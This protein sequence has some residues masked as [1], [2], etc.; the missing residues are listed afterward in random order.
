MRGRSQGHERPPP[1]PAVCRRAR[2]VHNR[3]G[4]TD[5]A[6]FGRSGG[7]QGTSLNLG[8]SVS[9][10]AE[11]SANFV[12]TE[13]VRSAALKSGVSPNETA[14]LVKVYSEA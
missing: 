3:R 7:L 8:A 2:V 10:A 5:R 13:E 6:R 11:K 14:A 12:S 9:V 1:S 4:D